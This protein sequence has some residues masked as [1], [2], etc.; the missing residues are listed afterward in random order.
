MSP[1]GRTRGSRT[2]IQKINTLAQLKTPNFKNPRAVTP[3]RVNESPK[4]KKLKPLVLPL[5]S[6]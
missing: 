6:V 5:L 1:K 4:T 3:E 2:G